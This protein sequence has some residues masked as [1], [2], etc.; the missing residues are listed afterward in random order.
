MPLLA[1]GRRPE[2]PTREELIRQGMTPLQADH[3]LV[4]V[5][6]LEVIEE[7]FMRWVMCFGGIVCMLL[8]VSLGLFVLLIYSYVSERHKE[9]DVPL[10]TWFIVAVS[11][12]LYNVNLNGKSI[13]QQV[14]R[15]VCR[16]QQVMDQ[17]LEPPPFRVRV[18]H[19]CVTGFV[20]VWHC[21]GLHWV[22]TSKTCSETAPR[23]Y[24]AVYIF[25]TFNIVF[26]IFTTL[27]TFGLS[28]MLAS[29][30]RRGLLPTSILPADLTAP[31]GTLECQETVTYSPEL[32]CDSPQCPTCLE[33]F[34]KEHNIKK[35]VCG[36]FFHEECLAPWLR[37][38]RYCPLCRSDLA[39]G[40]QGQAIG[41]TTA[42][43]DPEE[44]A[45]QQPENAAA[46]G[47]ALPDMV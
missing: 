32:L 2:P 23:L 20:F 21:I 1:R 46:A 30:L 18:Y 33:D 35:T 16:Y 15:L 17:R 22:R 28:Q 29:L 44:R 3:E 41:S 4:R 6:E 25:A 12:I 24:R 10:G 31:E 27:S 14:I 47:E 43:D 13:H 38:N 40:L 34:T 8:P 45:A 19:R 11:N 42:M 5:H 37:I 9:C 36:H 26:N 7:N 39:R